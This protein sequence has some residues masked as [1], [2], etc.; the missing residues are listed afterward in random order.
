MTANKKATTE[1]TATETSKSRVYGAAIA[2]LRTKY[3]A[4]FK[5]IL[6][7]EYE[8]AGL[9]Y[10]RRLTPKDKAKVNVAALLEQFPD[11]RDELLA[12]KPDRDDDP[13]HTEPDVPGGEP[14]F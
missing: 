11:L 6:A 2:R 1:A 14:N 10:N 9:P 8:K 7:E 12:D 3:D 5:D 13:V 4:E